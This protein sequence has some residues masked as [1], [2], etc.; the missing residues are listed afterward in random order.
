MEYKLFNICMVLALLSCSCKGRTDGATYN[1]YNTDDATKIDIIADKGN[2]NIVAD[3]AR[4]PWSDDVLVDSMVEISA[5]GFRPLTPER[6]S[7]LFDY[8]LYCHNEDANET[9]YSRVGQEL[10]CSD[11]FFREI[12]NGAADLN[13]AQQMK[14][15]QCLDLAL[16]DYAG[17]YYET[18]GLSEK[19]IIAKTGYGSNNTWDKL[20]GQ[21]RQLKPQLGKTRFCE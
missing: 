12:K 15:L 19:E 18:V 16:F 7:I 21:I 20:A 9:F 2:P 13:K 10:L 4:G 8:F 11:T 1:V 5:S 6:L 17:L 14:I 3:K